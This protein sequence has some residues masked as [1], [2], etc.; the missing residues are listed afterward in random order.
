[1]EGYT[2][3][4]DFMG[5]HPEPASVLRFSDIN[6]QNI[7]YLQAEIYGLREDLRKAEVQNPISTSEDRNN[8]S[9]DWY[10]LAHTQDNN[11]V[12]NQKWQKVGQL[13]GLLKEYGKH[14]KI[15]QL[16]RG[17]LATS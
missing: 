2:K 17:R 15:V 11:D 16:R 8:F 7:I 13:K 4:A 12:R 5:R 9:L 6:L 10:T 14:P 1:M 3:I